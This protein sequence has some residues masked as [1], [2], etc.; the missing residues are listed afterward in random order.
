MNAPNESGSAE[1]SDLAY[2]DGT[3]AKA[4]TDLRHDAR[5]D[6]YCDLCGWRLVQIT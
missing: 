3:E 1:L 2:Q 5:Q 6:V 4:E